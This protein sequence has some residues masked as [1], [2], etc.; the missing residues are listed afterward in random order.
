VRRGEEGGEDSKIKLLVEPDGR[1]L[2]YV[3]TTVG[4]WWKLH[5]VDS[6]LLAYLDMTAAQEIEQATGVMIKSDGQRQSRRVS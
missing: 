3:L 4:L 2:P 5:H 6:T 1:A